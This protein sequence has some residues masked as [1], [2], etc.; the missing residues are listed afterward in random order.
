MFDQLFRM[1]HVLAR[2]ENGPLAED[3]RR[4]LSHC[5][6]QQMAPQTLGNIARFT[7]RVA[8][9]L[10][11]AERPGE[12]ITRIEIDAEAERWVNHLPKHRRT[13]N[14]RWLRVRFTGH[15][16]RWLT[17]LQ[18]LQ[19]PASRPATIRRSRCHICRLYGTRTWVV[20]ENYRVRQSD[21]SPVP[22]ASRGSGS[23]ARDADRGPGG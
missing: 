10:R 17:F 22:R 15:A 4:Y 3:R 7:L 1:P 16:V 18:R 9:A 20:A 11:L 8:E 5:A 14:G 12:V 23:S 6:E 2:L 21:D 13:R 19:S